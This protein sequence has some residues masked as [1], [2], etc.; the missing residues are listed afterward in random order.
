MYPDPSDWNNAATNSAW[1][2]DL[3]ANRSVCQTNGWNLI[4][5]VGGVLMARLATP[6]PT[7]DGSTIGADAVPDVSAGWTT[8]LLRALYAVAQ[9]D[10]APSDYLQ[11]IVSDAASSSVSAR[12][13][14]VAAWIVRDQT[15]VFSGDT[16]SPGRTAGSPADIQIPDGTLLPQWGAAP[17]SVQLGTPDCTPIPASDPISNASTT[18]VPFRMDVILVLVVIGV[19]VLGASLLTNK[20]PVRRLRNP[21]RARRISYA[22]HARRIR[23]PRVEHDT[24]LGRVQQTMAQFLGEQGALLPSTRFATNDRNDGLEIRHVDLS[25]LGPEGFAKIRSAAHRA[26]MHVVFT[27][28]DIGIYF[29]K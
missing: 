13:L 11:A 20:I 19:V 21:R 23:N 3:G 6:L 24:T 27:N 2:Y 7:F 8:D 18:V 10:G 28:N 26:G 12:T 1:V 17:R 15:Y 4:Y 14:A 29:R 9:H 25:A 22:S 5:S 16:P